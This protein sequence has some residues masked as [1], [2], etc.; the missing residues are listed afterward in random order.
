MPHSSAY[1]LCRRLLKVDVDQIYCVGFPEGD[2]T[3]TL[4]GWGHGRGASGRVSFVRRA[5][6]AVVLQ[7]SKR[8]ATVR[9]GWYWP[10]TRPLLNAPPPPPPPPEQCTDVV[11]G[12]VLLDVPCPWVGLKA[13]AVGVSLKECRITGAGLPRGEGL[14]LA[15]QVDK[16]LA[17]VASEDSEVRRWE[18]WGGE[19]RGEEGRGGVGSVEGKRREEDGVCL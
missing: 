15:A 4:G 7:L 6:T 8:L 3:P 16:G 11:V 19:R 13:C 12:S 1:S 10:D 2:L 14:H 5:A 17:R 9:I 18:G